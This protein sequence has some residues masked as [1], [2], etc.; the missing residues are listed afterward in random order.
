MP[1]DKSVVKFASLWL[2]EDHPWDCFRINSNSKFVI[3][4]KNEDSL[5]AFLPDYW[6]GKDRAM[7]FCS[8]PKPVS[9]W[10]QI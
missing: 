3:A 5:K 9:P 2:I 4:V 6:T 7:R 1:A 10:D 8:Q